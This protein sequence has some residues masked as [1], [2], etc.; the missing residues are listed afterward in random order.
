VSIQAD[1]YSPGAVLYALLAG[2]APF[3]TADPAALVGSVRRVRPKP[4]DALRDDVP[5]R[6]GA[7][8]AKSMAK[9]PADRYA[10]CGEFAR[11]LESAL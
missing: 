4:L 10:D 9:D 2:R 6:L 5:R 7:V 3:E 11:D 8:V 1:E